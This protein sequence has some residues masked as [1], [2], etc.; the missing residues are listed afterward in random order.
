M[1]SL[2][3]SRWVGQ[4]STTGLPEDFTCPVTLDQYVW[5]P[6]AFTRPVTLDRPGR[7]VFVQTATGCC[8]VSTPLLWDLEGVT[9]TDRTVYLPTFPTT[10]KTTHTKP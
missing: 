2:V 1:T 8:V 5:V 7:L 3:L 10:G 9:S 6:E 4:A